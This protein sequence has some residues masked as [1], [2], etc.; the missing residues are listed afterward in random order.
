MMTG[1]DCFF[2]F[3]F[4]FHAVGLVLSLTDAVQTSKKK[5]TFAAGG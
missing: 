1:V 2:L 3:Y 4:I 5:K